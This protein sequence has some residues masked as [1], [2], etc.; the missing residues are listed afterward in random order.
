[1][2][3]IRT[4]LK[5]SFIRESTMTGFAELEEKLLP[6]AEGSH[7]LRL[8]ALEKSI[9]QDRAHG[10]GLVGLGPDLHGMDGDATPAEQATLAT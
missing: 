3:G 2:T 9:F 4:F 8:D 1:M 5:L 10:H 7:S 6:R